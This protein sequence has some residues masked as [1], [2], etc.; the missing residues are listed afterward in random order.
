MWRRGW[1]GENPKMPPS[2]SVVN[3]VARSD[4]E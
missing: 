4:R 1:F 2:F 3:M